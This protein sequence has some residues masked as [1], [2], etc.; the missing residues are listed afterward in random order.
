MSRSTHSN[1]NVRNIRLRPSVNPLRR[2]R[3]ER[4]L[5]RMGQ[6]TEI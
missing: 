2:S 3:N 4:V 1:P 5:G 6:I